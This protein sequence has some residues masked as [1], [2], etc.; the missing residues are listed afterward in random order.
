LGDVSLHDGSDFDFQRH[1][2]AN[3]NAAATQRNEHRTPGLTGYD[4]NPLSR[5]KPE[6]IE[7]TMNVAAAIEGDDLDVLARPGLSQGK[8]TA[9]RHV[10]KWSLRRFCN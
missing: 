8:S 5:R 7:P 6:I 10:R 1:A 4:P 9:C 2:K 3:S